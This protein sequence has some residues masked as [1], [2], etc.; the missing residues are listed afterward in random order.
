MTF[1]KAL[2]PEVEAN[3]LAIPRKQRAMVRKGIDRGLVGE[4]D[5]GVDRFF[6]LYADNQHRHGTPPLARRYF[7]ALREAFGEDCEVL[8]VV[9]RAGVAV[10]SVLSFYL[11]RRSPAVL[12]RGQCAARAPSL[13][14]TS[15]TGT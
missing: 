14:T 8:T 7:E 1:R 13:P 5:R 15:S 6:E 3:L 9:D 10:S 12:R 4:I 2:L 11:P